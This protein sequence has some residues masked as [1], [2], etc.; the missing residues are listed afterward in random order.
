MKK[1]TNDKIFSESKLHF[2]RLETDQ[3]KSEIITA[4]EPLMNG[5]APLDGN[6]SNKSFNNDVFM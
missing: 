3:I 2:I 6:I 4:A 1:M 5:W